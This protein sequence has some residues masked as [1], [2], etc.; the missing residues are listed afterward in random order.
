MPIKIIS[1]NVDS[2]VCAARRTLLN[3]FI[4]DNDADI[5][6]LQETK[7][8][9]RVKLF[10]PKYNIIRGDVRRGYGGTAIFVRHGIPIRNV[11][12]GRGSINFTS[13]EIK[14]DSW[15]RIYSIYVTHGCGNI[16]DAYSNIFKSTSGSIMGGDF[17]SRHSSFGDASDNLYGVQLANCA[18][19]FGC[20]QSFITHLL[21]LRCWL[22]Y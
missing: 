2:I 1:L 3:E 18:N 9:N 13:I 19:L 22:L 14:L 20:H 6:L 4:N 16:F 21:S 15:Y 8:D 7:L 5:Y 11:S 10:F 12:I 17:N